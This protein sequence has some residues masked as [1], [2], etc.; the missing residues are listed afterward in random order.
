MFHNI[1]E[2]LTWT[3]EKRCPKCFLLT[4]CHLSDLRAVLDRFTPWLNVHDAS[5]VTTWYSHKTGLLQTIETGIYIQTVVCVVLKQDYAQNGKCSCFQMTMSTKCNMN[6]IV[7]TYMRFTQ[8][9][10]HIVNI[11]GK[12]YLKSIQEKTSFFHYIITSKSSIVSDKINKLF[13]YSLEAKLLFISNKISPNLNKPV[14]LCKIVNSDEKTPDFETHAHWSL[15]SQDNVWC[16]SQYKNLTTS[17]QDQHV[18]VPLILSHGQYLNF[19]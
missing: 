3:K 12:I 8:S 10:E 2:E 13:F 1:L 5:A 17:S 16:N 9:D 15:K 6:P 4:W 14:S 19:V 7:E 11:S 18:Y